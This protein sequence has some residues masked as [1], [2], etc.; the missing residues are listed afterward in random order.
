[1][2]SILAHTHSLAL[3]PEGDIGANF[4]DD[5]GDFMPWDTRILEAGPVSF[6]DHGVTVTNS[7]CLD[8]DA[9]GI[10]SGDGNWAVHELEVVAG[11]SDLNCFHLSSLERSVEM[12]ATNRGHG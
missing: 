10:G 5:A 3:L 12:T 7:T 11:I 6:L 4:V 8:F 1:M 9:D 2:A